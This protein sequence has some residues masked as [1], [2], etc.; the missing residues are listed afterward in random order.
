[1]LCDTKQNFVYVKF[2]FILSFREINMDLDD[3]IFD[4]LLFGSLVVYMIV[5]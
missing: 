1:M 5:A 3:F 2:M 4:L